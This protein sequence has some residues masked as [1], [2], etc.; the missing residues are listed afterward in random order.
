MTGD[1]LKWKVA[2]C[3][4][5]GKVTNIDNSTWV[6]RMIVKLETFKD[7]NNY[8]LKKLHDSLAA[9]N[10]AIQS[11][12]T[13]IKNLMDLM[14]EEQLEKVKKINKATRELVKKN[15]K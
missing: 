15:R 6:Q 11:L 9:K 8:H 14:T 10:G 1:I 7:L 5:C 12:H 13:T 3:K 4:H 2:T